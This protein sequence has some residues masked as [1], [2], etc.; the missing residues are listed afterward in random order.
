M[1]VAQGDILAPNL[2]AIYL[3]A[4]IEENA[5]L[6]ELAS[7]GKLYAYA[8]D[9]VVITENE[10]ELTEAINALASLEQK[11]NLCLNKK[12]S[13]ILSKDPVYGA[14]NKEDDKREFL[15][16]Q[17]RCY[18]DLLG[19]K[20]FTTKTE[21]LKAA[22]KAVKK[23]LL[24]MQGQFRC[25][26]QRL[27]QAIVAAYVRSVISYH[28][29]PLFAAGLVVRKDVDQRE[30][31][32]MKK[33]LGIASSASQNVVMNIYGTNYTSIGDQVA[34]AGTKLRLHTKSLKDFASKHEEHLLFEELICKES[35]LEE[36]DPIA[37]Q[38]WKSQ[39][40]AAKK[41]YARTR[42]SVT[43]LPLIQRL[44]L[45]TAQGR[46][47]VHGHYKCYE[48]VT[49]TVAEKDLPQHWLK[50]PEFLSEL[51]IRSKLKPDHYR[52]ALNEPDNNILLKP[53]SEQVDLHKHYTAIADSIKALEEQGVWRSRDHVYSTA[54]AK[55]KGGANPI[56]VTR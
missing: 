30:I 15:G 9:I 22:E 55:Q 17:V 38:K 41:E 47:H 44:M 16:V 32:L 51:S 28:Y 26:D 46:V 18:L 19:M 1:G 45:V 48:C 4:A 53:K 12:K 24:S 42:A 52:A 13:Q 20:I 50:C 23:K 37:Y 33:V 27:N 6:K 40:N 35:K 34:E 14:I 54:K 11:W 49:C 5:C 3:D 43:V 7:E 2:F 39:K 36:L 56:A 8:D 21:T 31:I 10:A 29:T 25:V